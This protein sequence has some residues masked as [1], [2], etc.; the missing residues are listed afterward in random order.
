MPTVRV[1]K[2]DL[3]GTAARYEGT[4][5][6]NSFDFRNGRKIYLESKAI[7]F[8]EGLNGYDFARVKS[9]LERLSPVP[10]PMD[11]LVNKIRPN[12]FKAKNVEGNLLSFIIKYS[13]SSTSVI[14]S[15]IQLN[16][17]VLGSKNSAKDERVAMYH[18]DKVRPNVHFNA[19]S[20]KA[21]VRELQLAWQANSRA[22]LSIDTSHA[23]VNGMLN[24]LQKAVWLMG[25][26]SEHA[27]AE[28]KLK[29]YTLFHNPSE[30]AVLDFYE[31]V[32]G[33]L[34]GVT[35]NGRYLA[36]VLAQVQARGKPVKWTVHSQGGIIFKEAVAYHLKN[37]PGRSLNKNSVVVHSGGNNKKGLNRLL[38]QVG[39]KKAGPD[40][41]NPMDAVPNLAGGNDLRLS[42]IKRSVRFLG[43]VIGVGDPGAEESPHT[44]P[45]ISLEAYRHFL[46]S[47]GDHKRAGQV[48]RYMQ[49][50]AK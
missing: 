46:T 7:R 10:S 49:K 18:V 16:Q 6:S 28:D 14:V 47:A 24:N 34:G 12:F 29:E 17:A 44:L 30:E 2:S 37:F 38:Q 33:N 48:A 23:A 35:E 13:L 27:Y 5:D 41:D 39:I 19:Q 11:G 45:F 40:N 4:S 20:T 50:L 22:V 42:S 31:S 9:E 32:Q 26:H 1:S 8:W 3:I 43:K 36:A 21:G 15:S 25:V